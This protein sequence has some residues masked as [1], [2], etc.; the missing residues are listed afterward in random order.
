MVLCTKPGTS[1]ILAQSSNYLSPQIYYHDGALLSWPNSVVGFPSLNLR[2]ETSSCPPP[3]QHRF[4]ESSAASSI[5]K[6]TAYSVPTSPM[7]P[8]RP[9]ESSPTGTPG[10]LPKTE[11]KPED[12]SSSVKKRLQSSTRTGQAC[13]RCKVCCRPRRAIHQGDAKLTNCL[14]TQNTMRWT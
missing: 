8:K 13:D 1:Q 6:R 12:F 10:K 11:T 9:S 3:R 7:P 4:P 14:D 5:R 2:F